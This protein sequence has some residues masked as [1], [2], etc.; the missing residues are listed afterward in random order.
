MT[1]EPNR[2]ISSPTRDRDG[3]Q[4]LDIDYYAPFLLSAVSS[5]WQRQ[6]SAIYRRDFNLGI[7]DWRVIAMINIEPEITAN[8]ICE[9]IRLD[10]AAVSRSLKLLEAR[11]LATFEASGSDPRRRKWW[12]TDAGQA[13][14]RDILAIALECESRMLDGIDPE[15][16]EI[17]LKVM[18]GMLTNL[19]R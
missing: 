6:T 2:R 10:K 14:H 4:V 19:D 18:R 8:R 3:V 17:H 7:V 1:D 11:G 9:V 16:V 5:A 15:D 12:L 13:V